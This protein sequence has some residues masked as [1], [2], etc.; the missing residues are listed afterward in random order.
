MF[1]N[2]A[3]FYVLPLPQGAYMGIYRTWD[4]KNGKTSDFVSTPLA[5]ELSSRSLI[6]TAASDR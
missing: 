5:G 1:H 6:P 3:F 2:Y 4:Q